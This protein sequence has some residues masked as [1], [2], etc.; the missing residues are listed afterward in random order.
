MWSH[1]RQM[2]AM[3]AGRIS[4]QHWKNIEYV[5]ISYGGTWP[6]NFSNLYGIFLE[7]NYYPE[8]RVWNMKIQRTKMDSS[9]YFVH[10]NKN[11]ITKKN[12]RFT[13]TN[14]MKKGIQMCWSCKSDFF[15]SAD[16]SQIKI[17]MFNT[18]L[19]FLLNHVIQI[20]QKIT[21]FSCYTWQTDFV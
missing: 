15:L 5:F 19:F 10:W 8:T 14:N 9:F 12:S 18:V 4:V 3:F 6:H 2:L 7:Y 1:S 13:F 11:K 21:W 20:C 16:F 17:I